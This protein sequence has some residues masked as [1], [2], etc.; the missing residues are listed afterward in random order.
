MSA[1]ALNELAAYRS[2][3]MPRCEA[4]TMVVSIT[5]SLSESREEF[6]A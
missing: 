2:W 6:H 4:A 1:T 3:R 5:A